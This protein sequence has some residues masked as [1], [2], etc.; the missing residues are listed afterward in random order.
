MKSTLKHANYLFASPVAKAKLRELIYLV[1][2]RTENGKK[3]VYHI[4]CNS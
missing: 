3:I 2:L 1:I 4:K